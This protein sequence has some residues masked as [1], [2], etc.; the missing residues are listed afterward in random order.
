MTPVK[1]ENYE[2]IIKE[3]EKETSTG[4]K[5]ILEVS[6]GMIANKEIVPGAC[7]DYVNAV[8]DRAG[9][10]RSKRT[11]VFKGKYEGPYVKLEQIIPGDWLYYVNHS[12]HNIEHSGIFVDWIDE[13]KREALMIS[14]AGG[15]Q[16]RPAEYKKYLIN[17]IYNVIR[18]RD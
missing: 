8:Y 5:K 7:W 11:T 10:S 16:K 13:K 6:K 14:Y 18:A 17:K 12:F 15:N 9:Y 4:G 1:D 3:A 2:K